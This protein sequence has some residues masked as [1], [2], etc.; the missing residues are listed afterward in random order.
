MDLDVS[1]PV[2]WEEIIA[3]FEERN[4]KPLR[5]CQGS[6]VHWRSRAKLA[7][8][9]TSEQPLIGLF[10]KGSHDVMPIPFCQIHHPAINLAVE[11]IKKIIV[12]NKLRLYNE[13]T[14]EGDLRYIQLIVHR[15]T[16]KIQASFVLNAK[17]INSKA[18][19]KWESILKKFQEGTTK[20]L[21]H[22]IWLNFNDRMTNTIFG[23]NWHK[24]YGEDLLWEKIGNISVCYQPSSFGQAN[25]ELFEKMLV[26]LESII[27][28][29]S[30]I[31][32]FYA[33]VGVIGLFVASKSE[34]V[35]C[36]ELNP[37]AEYC[38]SRSRFRLPKDVASKVSF[39]TGV[40]ANMLSIL[41]GA[42][43]AIVDP[44]RKGLDGAV[45]A[46]L[47]TAP[48]LKQIVYI[49]CG[50]DGFKKDCDILLESGWRLSHGEGYWFFPG[51]N[52]VEILAIFKKQ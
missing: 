41:D 31:A 30:K 21:W 40:A 19:V 3:Y 27:P 22:S 25:L 43:V 5:L 35:R 36:S 47:Q 37:N 50:W 33:G 2:L 23:E 8:R 46:A 24:C 9:G 44:P 49:S 26:R 1:S 20:D 16:G 42:D 15:A 11:H 6:R 52:Q 10:K 45:L 7:V 14:G 38:F 4:I 51:S 39:H 17:N 18:S 48:D 34:W 28:S 12:E 29:Q 32:E 13:Q